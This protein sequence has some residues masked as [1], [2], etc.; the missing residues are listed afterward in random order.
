[1]DWEEDAEQAA[2]RGQG[3]AG[4]STQQSNRASSSGALPY[5]DAGPQYTYPNAFA[6]SHEYMHPV[7]ASSAAYPAGQGHQD[8]SSLQQFIAHASGSRSTPQY[9]H[10][11]QYAFAGPLSGSHIGSDPYQTYH[12]PS[13]SVQQFAHNPQYDQ[14]TTSSSSFRPVVNP[15]QFSSTG[16]S[17]V[18]AHGWNGQTLV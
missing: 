7:Y 11:E 1:M 6:P 8:V 16:V 18:H 4:P 5:P 2:Y 9:T 10:H 15:A 12:Q 3:R 14:P 13:H 17:V